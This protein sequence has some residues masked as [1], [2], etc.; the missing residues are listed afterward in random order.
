VS[1]VVEDANDDGGMTANGQKGGRL[2]CSTEAS[3]PNARISRLDRAGRDRFG[4]AATRISDRVM[5]G[6]LIARHL[7]V[8]VA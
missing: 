5:P 7:C 6:E 8:H 3:Q 2:V 1:V 4:R